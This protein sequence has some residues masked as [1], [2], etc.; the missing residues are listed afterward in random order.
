MAPAILSLDLEC[1]FLDGNLRAV[2]VDQTAD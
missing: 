1:P 2:P